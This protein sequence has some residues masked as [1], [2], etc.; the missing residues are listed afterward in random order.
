MQVTCLLIADVQTRGVMLP[1]Y[2]PGDKIVNRNPWKR[3]HN[4]YMPAGALHS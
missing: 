2:Y 4:I 3:G 1:C